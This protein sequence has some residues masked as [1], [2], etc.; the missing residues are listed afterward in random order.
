[1]SSPFLDDPNLGDLEKKY[2]TK[3]IDSN[4][5]SVVGPFVPEFEEKFAQYVGSEKAVSTQS[6]TAALHMALYQLEIGE[7]DEVIVT[8]S[9]Q[10]NPYNG[11]VYH[12]KVISRIEFK[13][14]GDTQLTTENYK[15]LEEIGYKG[16]QIPA[17]H[18]IKSEN[19]V[20]KM[21]G[22]NY[23]IKEIEVELIK[24]GEDIL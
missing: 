23:R 13:N 16:K 8:Y 6:G 4:F 14:K 2:L 20:L 11:K 5:V 19:G 3:A 22:L 10:D 9:I 15:L 18:L 21:G 7:G 1:M 24:D 12:N 17:A